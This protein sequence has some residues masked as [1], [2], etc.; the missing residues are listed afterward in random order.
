MYELS[1]V[2]FVEDKDVPSA[3][4]ILSGVCAQPPWESTHHVHFY[5]GPGR[6]SGMVNPSPTPTPLQKDVPALWKEIDRALSRQSYQIQV[7]HE[8][9][10]ADFGKAEAVD[11]DADPAILRWVDFPE[12]AQAVVGIEK[13][14]ITQRKKVEIWGQ[15]NLHSLVKGKGYR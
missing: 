9:S 4:S 6:P 12:P 15:K 1:L 11:Y 3:V 8:V 10:R 2:G 7:R 14:A 13:G 5:R